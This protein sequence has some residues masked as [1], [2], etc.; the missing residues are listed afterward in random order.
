MLRLRGSEEQQACA[1]LRARDQAEVVGTINKKVKTDLQSL[2][3]DA[4][5]HALAMLSDGK[6]DAAKVLEGRRDA[7]IKILNILKQMCV[8]AEPEPGA[9]TPLTLL[10]DPLDAMGSMDYEE[11]AKVISEVKSSL[12]ELTTKLLK[13]KETAV[14]TALLKMVLR[15]PLNWE[16]CGE[17]LSQK[18]R[19]LIAKEP[20]ENLITFIRMAAEAKAV[21]FGECLASSTM[22]K[23]FGVDPAVALDALDAMVSGGFGLDG[24]PAMLPMFIPKASLEVSARIVAGLAEQN[25][26]GPSFDACWEAVVSKEGGLDALPNDLRERLQSCRKSRERSR[27]RERQSKGSE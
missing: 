12:I 3:T 14:D 23:L 4:I 18:G 20:V 2:P 10:W 17:H 6:A 24:V 15:M 22:M 16:T 27:S 8:N 21:K 19:Q 9:I 25:I 5:A 7:Q 1:I 26:S 13:H 11:V